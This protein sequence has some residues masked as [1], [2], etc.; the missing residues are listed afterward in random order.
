MARGGRNNVRD[1]ESEGTD[2]WMEKWR[3]KME[4]IEGRR[5]LR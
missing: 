2:G 3:R 5:K 1:G 4:V